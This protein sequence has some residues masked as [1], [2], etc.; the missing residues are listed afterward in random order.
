MARALR[1]VPAGTAAFGLVLA[2]ASPA[3]VAGVANA[4]IPGAPKGNPLAGLPWGNFSG[5]G[6]EV[7]PAYRAATGRQR[8]LL[9]LIALRPRVRWFGLW[10]PPAEA[11]ARQYIANVIGGNPNV[12]AQLAVFRMQPWEGEACTRLPTAAEQASYKQWINGFAAGIG[13]ARVAL[14][15]QPDLPFAA[16]APHRSPLPLRLVSYAAQKFSSLPHTSV[17]IDAGAADW[18]TVGTAVSL[19]RG[20][21][22]RFTRGFAL[23]ATH[24]DSTERQ[25]LMGAQVVRALARKGIA[26]RH[27][28]INTATNGRPFTFQQVGPAAFQKAAVCRSRKSVRCVTLGIPPTPD[29]AN[30]RWGLSRHA[31]SLAAGMVDAYLWIGR[32]W[33]DNQSDPFDLQR[34]LALASSTPF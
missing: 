16:C 2:V 6:E 1:A 7:F 15:L 24:Y 22:V 19:L 17:Y 29:V 11:T 33:L 21:G 34:S 26:G 12:L 10:N 18:V 27:F 8:Y 32:P 13:S 5:P 3:A 31:R 4:G 30:P 9:G 23:N 20:A 28:V 25:I 14:I